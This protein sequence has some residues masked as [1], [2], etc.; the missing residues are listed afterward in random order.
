VHM[1]AVRLDRGGATNWGNGTVPRFKCDRMPTTRATE[2]LGR[3]YGVLCYVRD[4]TISR[5]MSTPYGQGGS[6]QTLY[7]VVGHTTNCMHKTL[8]YNA[9]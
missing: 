3:A 9:S 1:V 4:A 7:N 6:H 8:S 5:H 2:V